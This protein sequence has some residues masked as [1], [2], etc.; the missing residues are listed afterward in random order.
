MPLISS[1]ARPGWAASCGGSGFYDQHPVGMERAADAPEGL[2]TLQSRTDPEAAG[3]GDRGATITLGALLDRVNPE[4]KRRAPTLFA[5]LTRGSFD[6]LWAD[7]STKVA[8]VYRR[9]WWGVG[10]IIAGRRP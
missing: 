3:P 10:L 4:R 9:V 6:A 8:G 2:P 1:T 7:V 5:D